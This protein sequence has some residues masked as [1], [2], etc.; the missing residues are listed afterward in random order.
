MSSIR[1]ENFGEGIAGGFKPALL[2]MSGKVAGFAATFFIPVVLARI[3]DP[4][5]FGTYRQLFLIY[6]TLYGVVQLGMAESLFYFLPMARRNPGRY[7]TNAALVIGAG[8]I[9]CLLCLQS[10]RGTITGWLSNDAL[11]DPL[12]LLGLFLLFMAVSA[13][14]EIVMI[15]QGRYGW[16]A[17]SYGLSDILRAVFIVPPPVNPNAVSTAGSAS[18][19]LII[20]WR[21][22]SIA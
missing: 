16:A 15:A 10:A 5:Q 21:I 2:L 22:R 3:F 9:V 19:I 18:M 12:P 11:G 6:A 14:L 8:G 4:A 1:Q 20:C 13:P 17:L 7:A